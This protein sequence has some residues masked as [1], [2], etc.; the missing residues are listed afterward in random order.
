M[1]KHTY[2]HSY[3]GDKSEAVPVEKR[4]LIRKNNLKNKED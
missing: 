2:G 4:Y 3:R 1:G